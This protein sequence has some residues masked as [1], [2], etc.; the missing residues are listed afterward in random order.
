MVHREPMG[1][2]IGVVA[3]I[4]ERGVFYL[5]RIEL[6][7]QFQGR[8]LGAQL[9][10]DLLTQARHN[11]AHAAELHVLK[12]NR[13]KSLYERLGFQT[14]ADEPPKLHM[15]LNFPSTPSPAAR[16]SAWIRSIEDIAAVARQR[17]TDVKCFAL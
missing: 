15:R 5:S 12:A 1:E 14:I 13:A 8:G 9:I 10:R 6:R 4:D 2:P 11:G 7:T 3:G 17:S 16:N